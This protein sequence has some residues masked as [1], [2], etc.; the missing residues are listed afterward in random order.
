MSNWLKVP[1]VLTS[2]HPIPRTVLVPPRGK[3]NITPLHSLSHSHNSP[4]L[5][6]KATSSQLSRTPYSALVRAMMP[7]SL[8]S[9]PSPPSLC[10]TLS[11]RPSSPAGANVLVPNYCTSLS[12]HNISLTP[13]LAPPQLHS[14]P[15][16]LTIY[17]SLRCLYVTY[18]PLLAS[19]FAPTG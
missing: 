19:L 4:Q 3:S 15:S 10:L 2:T 14:K 18:M 17:Q 13:P 16:A 9:S 6:L 5:P 11:T 7:N 1:R 8:S 12:G